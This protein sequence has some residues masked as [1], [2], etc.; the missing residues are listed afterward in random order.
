MVRVGVQ[1]AIRLA[2]VANDGID[3]GNGIVPDFQ[4]IADSI[5]NEEAISFRNEDLDYIGASLLCESETSLK[6]T[7]INKTVIGVEQLKEKYDIKLP[8]ND[9]HQVDISAKG[10]FVWIKIKNIKPTELGKDEKL[11]DICR[12]LYLYNCAALE[13]IDGEQ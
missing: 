1:N 13:Y 6:L 12:A 7:F 2:I 10:S 11:M 4:N 5:Q 8:E 9:M 3:N